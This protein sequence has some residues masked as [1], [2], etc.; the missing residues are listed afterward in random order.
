MTPL[1]LPSREA[2]ST[3]LLL[4]GLGGAVLATGPAGQTGLPFLCA[5]AVVV[6]GALVWPA[7]ARKG[8]PGWLL[9]PLLV[10]LPCLCAVSYAAPSA[11]L[12]GSL[13]L[14]LCALCAGAGARGLHGS[15][16]G[17]VYLPVMVLAF[18]GPYAADYLAA[19]FG[20]ATAGVPW[21]ALSP[22]GAAEEVAGGGGVSP[23]A[24][25]ILLVW[26]ILALPLARRRVP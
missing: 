10:G 26:P 16:A 14:L 24:C 5:A 25:L 20:P 21:R 2:G 8:G 22:L 23:G 11:S 15:R 3:L 7:V 17:D 1:T 9:L 18:L 12:T 13:I 6:H 19:E 4:L